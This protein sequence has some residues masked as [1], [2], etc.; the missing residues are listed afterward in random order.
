MTVAISTAVTQA[1]QPAAA[2]PQVQF[3]PDSNTSRMQQCICN[4][5]TRASIL[6]KLYC[7]RQHGGLTRAK[8]LNLERIM[9]IVSISIRIFS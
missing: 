9:G 3:A 6:D 8:Q 7:A 1:L 4:K 5:S 2:T